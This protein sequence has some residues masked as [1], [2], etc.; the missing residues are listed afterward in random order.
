MRKEIVDAIY[1]L[2]SNI[3]SLKGSDGTI[4]IYKYPKSDPDGYPAVLIGSMGM[5]SRIT[6]T[7]TD[8]RDYIFSVRLVQEKISDNFGAEKAER[9]AMQREDDILTELDN[10]NDLGLSYILRTLPAKNQWGYADNNHRIVIDFTLKVQVTA[11]II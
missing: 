4:R 3:T 7:H 2:L 9:V 11:T 10:N 8:L 6:D 1:N 5:E